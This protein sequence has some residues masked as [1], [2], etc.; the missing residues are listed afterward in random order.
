MVT[1]VRRGD[2][3]TPAEPCIGIAPVAVPG[4]RNTRANGASLSL[5]EPLR[6]S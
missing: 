4:T 2:G 5:T 1:G 6:S 3:L